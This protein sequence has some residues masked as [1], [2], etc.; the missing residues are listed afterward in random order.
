MGQNWENVHDLAPGQCS[1]LDRS[2]YS[3]E[4]SRITILYPIIGPDDFSISWQNGR[5]TGISSVLTYINALQSPDQ[6]QSF[7]VY[8]DGQG[9]FVVTRV[10]LIAPAQIAPASGTVFNHYPRTMTL[11]WAPV[12]GATKYVVQVDCF[13]CCEAGAC[14]TDVGRTSY[15]QQSV[16]DTQYTFHFVGA[17]PGRWRVWAVGADGREGPRSAW[18]EFR[19][20]K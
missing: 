2:I 15:G 14:C 5:V 9:N 7:D 13:H 8:N 11:R 6:F 19:Y 16:T 17:Q 10:G 18:W 1:W 12:A 3:D 20:T 4:P